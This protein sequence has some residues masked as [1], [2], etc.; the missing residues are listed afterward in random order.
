MVLKV[1]WGIIGL[2]SLIVFLTV[3]IDWMRWNPSDNTL[4]GRIKSVFKYRLLMMIK[5]II[6][7]LLIVIAAMTLLL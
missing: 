6:P 4:G 1:L 3:V 7:G 2:W 5:M